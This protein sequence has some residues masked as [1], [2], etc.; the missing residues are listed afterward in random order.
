MKL[1]RPLSVQTLFAPFVSGAA[2]SAT[3]RAWNLQNVFF[4]CR[5]A[6]ILLIRRRRG[7][8]IGSFLKPNIISLCDHVIKIQISRSL[9]T[10]CFCKEWLL[11]SELCPFP[12][13]FL[14]L[15]RTFAQQRRWTFRLCLFWRVNGDG[16]TRMRNQQLVTRRTNQF[17][18]INVNQIN[19]RFQMSF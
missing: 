14:Q 1:S 10:V 2:K 15:L 8:G 7:V 19:F 4:A 11:L 18:M 3:R 17:P 5:G 13:A 6:V 12:S 16:Q 9:A